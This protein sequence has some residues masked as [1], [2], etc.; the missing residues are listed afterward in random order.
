MEQVRLRQN[1]IITFDNFLMKF[2]KPSIET[3]FYDVETTVSEEFPSDAEMMKDLIY[4][5][6]FMVSEEIIE[7]ERSI[8]TFLELIGDLGG[9][10]D[11][12]ILVIAFFISPFS[13][14]FFQ[15]KFLRKLYLVKTQRLN[16]FQTPV[17][18]PLKKSNNKIKFKNLKQQIPESIESPDLIQETNLH[19]PIK[20]SIWQSLK[21]L[22]SPLFKCSKKDEELKVLQQ[23]K[24]K[25]CERID[26]DL[27][28]ERLIKHVR[29]T[30]LIAKTLYTDISKFHIHYHKNNVIDL[31]ASEGYQDPN[32]DQ[33][34]VNEDAGF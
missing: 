17:G 3:D 13:E 29:D 27:S 12:F 30:K 18:I 4:S 23:L 10:Q 34:Q 5:N 11:I 1:N 20:V 6:K 16:V 25:G 2:D 21:I 19:Y 22:F 26:K 14:H 9:V 28:I 7:H 33:A 24:Q 31:D 8:Y 15:M 32:L